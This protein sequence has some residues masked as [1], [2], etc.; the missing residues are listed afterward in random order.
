MHVFFSGSFCGVFLCEISR[1]KISQPV[2]LSE[3]CVRVLGV[4]ECLCNVEDTPLSSSV[5]PGLKVGNGPIRAQGVE[6]LSKH[7]PSP[8]S[9]LRLNSDAVG[10]S[11]GEIKQEKMTLLH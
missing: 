6:P 8:S 2:E 9:W 10:N 7:K 3:E 1:R 11:A 4:C 5:S